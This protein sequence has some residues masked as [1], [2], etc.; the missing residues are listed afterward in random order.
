[1]AVLAM[2]MVGVVRVEVSHDEPL[3]GKEYQESDE[4]SDEYIVWFSNHFDGLWQ[5]VQ[6]A[7]SQEGAGGE[8]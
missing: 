7:H 6:E 4:R 5:K 1:M 3:Q 8:G 2:C